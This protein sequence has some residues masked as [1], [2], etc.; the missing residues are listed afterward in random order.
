MAGC[1]ITLTK[2]DD[3]ITSLLAAPAEIANRTF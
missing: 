3:E 2:L 1:S